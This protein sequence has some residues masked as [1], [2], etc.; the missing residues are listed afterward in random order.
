[1]LQATTQPDWT[2]AFSRSPAKDTI[3]SKPIARSVGAVTYGTV[4]IEGPN[5]FFRRAGDPAKPAFVL[6]H[7]FPSSS[8]M[9]RDLLPR[10]AER[11]Y[12]IA[13]DLIGF[14]YSDAPPEDAFAVGF[15]LHS[16]RIREATACHDCE[17]TLLPRGP[18][19]AAFSRA[20]RQHG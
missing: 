7:G 1:M 12:V 9:F 19:L 4:E 18:A 15:D 6:L 20:T 8:H 11:Y 17:G 2:D 16:L 14:G 3:M 5:V 10:L 13:P